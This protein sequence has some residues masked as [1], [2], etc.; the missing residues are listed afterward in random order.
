MASNDQMFA[1]KATCWAK[2]DAV[3]VTTDVLYT[4]TTRRG[5]L[6]DNWAK[7]P[8]N[9]LCRLEVQIRYNKFVK[10]YP[11]LKKEP[12]I[13]LLANS[14]HYGMKTSFRALVLVLR[15]NALFSGF[16]TFLKIV[17]NHTLK[18]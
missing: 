7:D 5:S 12:V 6:M 2:D 14:F 16:G 4:V 1:A 17:N 11:F 15:K 3:A 10:D 9:Y 18:L 8:D 13:I